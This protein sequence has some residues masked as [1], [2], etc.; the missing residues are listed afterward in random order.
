MTALEYLKTKE[1]SFDY[2]NLKVASEWME[3]YH[4]LRVAESNTWVKVERFIKPTEDQLI[5][6]AVLF[7]DG[8]LE[9]EKLADMLALVDFVVDRLYE[10][11]DI[12]KPTINELID[13]EREINPDTTA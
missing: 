1:D 2:I 6:A 5:K 13:I 9:R 4:A 10:N 7:N 12:T 11:G 8:K 3:S